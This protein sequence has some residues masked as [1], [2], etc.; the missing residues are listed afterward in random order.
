MEIKP[1]LASPPLPPQPQPEEGLQVLGVAPTKR[2]S[3]SQRFNSAFPR[4]EQIASKVLWRPLGI[5]V[6]N[7]G[8][9]SQSTG[10]Q[11][12]KSDH[13]MPQSDHLNGVGIKG[14][15]LMT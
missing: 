8:L 14:S 11:S 7:A 12:Q 3:G 2:L 10:L 6:G 4:L 9:Q 1:S 5:F 15:L 13:S